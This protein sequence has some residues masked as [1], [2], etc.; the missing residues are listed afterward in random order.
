MNKAVFLDRD[1]VINEILVVEGKPVT[2]KKVE[3]FRIL[4]GVKEALTAVKEG[5]Y[6]ILVVTNQPDIPRG[7]LTLEELERMHVILSRSL[8]IDRI[9]M[10]LHDNDDGCECRKPKPGMLL[11]AA[12]EWDLD[13]SASYMIG[14]RWKDIEAGAK[15][16][17]TTI[18]VKSLCSTEQYHHGRRRT[19]CPDHAVRDLAEAVRIILAEKVK[20]Q[21]EWGR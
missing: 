1:G 20:T 6:R 9:Y 16:G 21:D 14:D 15:A 18:L 17:C 7:A 13:L 8:P 5:G 4:P 3:D 12:E 10:C 2:P 19:V 11:Q